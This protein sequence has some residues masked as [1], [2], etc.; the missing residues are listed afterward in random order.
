[1]YSEGISIDEATLL[2]NKNL[3]LGDSGQYIR[4]LNYLINVVSYFDS[5]IPFLDLSGDLFTEDTEDVVK[6]FQRK[7]N[8][9]ENG[10]VSP[11]VWYR[12][13]EESK[14]K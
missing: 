11:I 9:E 4:T 1:M 8:L 2:F 3:K 13:V 6:A 5:S 7:Y 10:V 14:E 12:I